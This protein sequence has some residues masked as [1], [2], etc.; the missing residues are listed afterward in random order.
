MTG[1]GAIFNTFGVTAGESVVVF[2]AGA[3]GLSAVMAANISQAKIV[4][5]IDVHQDRLA[6]AKELGATH[7]LQ[8]N[9]PDL[10]ENL[11]NCCPSGF[12][13]SL[14]TSSQEAAFH[15]ALSSLAARGTCGLVTIP[16]DGQPF[17]F[18]PFELMVK[19]VRLEGIMLGSS[20]PR[21]L[22]P[23]LIAYHRQ[24]LFPYERLV[25]TY[26]FNNINTAFADAKKGGVIKPVLLMN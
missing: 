6:L 16:H 2:G 7:T 12:N 8:A 5:A 21:E 25:K 14:E 3:V 10:A 13:Y 9:D 4:V 1:A 23:K 18:S 24:G 19:C 26:K 20:A 11:R 15:L 22:L 17:P